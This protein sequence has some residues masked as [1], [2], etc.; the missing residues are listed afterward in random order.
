[1]RRRPDRLLQRLVC[2][3][4]HRLHLG[5]EP[6][7]LFGGHDA[8]FLETAHELLADG[9]MTADS[10]GHQR[11]R[12]RGLVLFVVPVPPVADEVDDDVVAEPSPEREREPDRRD[13]RLGIVGVHVDDRCVESLGEVARVAR[14]APLLGPGREADLVVRDQVQRAPGRIPVEVQEVQRLGDDALSGER[15]VSVDENRQGDRGIVQAL[16]RRPVGL[17]GARPPLDD[18][19]HRFE[20]ARVRGQGDDD[21]RA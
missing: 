2:R 10:L 16:P 4:Q 12:V 15:G 5:D 17:I 11:L 20:V 18:G 9:G 3:A 21:R 13:G 19:I 8:A 6:I 7:G 14:G 1:M